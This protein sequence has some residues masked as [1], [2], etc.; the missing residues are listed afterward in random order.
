MLWIREILG[1]RLPMPKCQKCGQ[2][3]TITTNFTC[4]YCG[5][6]ISDED[7]LK[8]FQHRKIVLSRVERTIRLL[9]QVGHDTKIYPKIQPNV[10]K[11]GIVSLIYLVVIIEERPVFVIWF[12]VVLVVVKFDC[13][14]WFIHLVIKLISYVFFVCLN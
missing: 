11:I 10:L 9:D 6:P 7:T 13:N 8:I 2:W 4:S 3:S 12:Y 14:N 1:E 5:K